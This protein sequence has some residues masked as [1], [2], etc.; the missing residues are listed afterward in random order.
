MRFA[1]IFLLFLVF[2]GSGCRTSGRKSS[3]E[4]P[5]DETQAGRAADAEASKDSPIAGTTA[6]STPAKYKKLDFSSGSVP[7]DFAY[8]GRITDGARWIDSN[9]ENTLLVTERKQVRG[10]DDSIHFI[11][12]YLYAV[13]DGSTR[14]LWKIQD[15]AENYCDNG[16]G[17]TSPIDVRDIDGDGVAENMFVYNIAGGCDVSPIPYKLMMHSGEKKLAV[18]GTNSV[19]VPDYRERGE[20]NFDDAFNSAPREF[21]SAASDFWDRYVAPLRAD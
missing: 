14:L 7:G 10:Q 17:L 13:K 21:R 2:I 18:R 6:E 20:K 1:A 16:K 11:Y 8:E 19:E 15:N 3:A 12:G 5:A 9:G 4:T